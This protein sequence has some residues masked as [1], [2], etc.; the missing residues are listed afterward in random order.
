[1]SLISIIIP[2]YNEEKFIKKV[3]D[4][5]LAIDLVHL[6]FKKEI[7]VVDDGSIDKTQEIAKKFANIK[8]FSKKN[9]GKGS[10]VQMGLSHALGDYF[11][12]QDADSE[13]FAEDIVT[14]LKCLKE[15]PKAVVYGSR[16][17]SCRLL[18]DFFGIKIYARYK[19]QML[20][21]YIANISINLMTLFLYGKWLSDTLTGYKLYPSKIIRDMYVKSKGFEADHE[22]TAKLLRLNVKIIE[23]PIRYL[24]RSISEGKKIGWRDGYKAIFTLFKYRIHS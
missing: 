14:M 12:V 5:V 13:Y 6:G 10:A 4:D 2:A 8:V 18:L 16:Y 7:I 17:M 22:M 3:I 20:S 23:V 1:M 9:A 11:I 21:S 24:P 15:N 19:D